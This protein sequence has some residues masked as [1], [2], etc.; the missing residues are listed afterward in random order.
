M[1]TTTEATRNDA[2][3]ADSRRV[4]LV[5]SDSHIGPTL[6]QLRSYCT[7]NLRDDLDAEVR[8]RDALRAAHESAFAIISNEVLDAQEWNC[9]TDGHHDMDARIRDMDVAGIAAQVIF[10]G[11]QNGEPIPFQGAP[12]SGVKA[13]THDLGRAAEG[14]KMYNRWLADAVSLQPERHVGAAQIPFWDVDATVAELRR[15]H[16]A[17][18]RA[19]NFPAMRAWLPAYDDAVWE[20]LWS[21]CEELDLSLACH[22]GGAVPAN[23]TGPASLALFAL[24]DGGTFGRRAVNWMTLGGVFERHPDLRIILTELSWLAVWFGPMMTEMDSVYYSSPQLG[25]REFLPKPPSEYLKKNVFIGASF[26]SR[27]EALAA[28]EGGYED[29]VIW[30]SDYPHCEG[31]WRYAD[32]PAEQRSFQLASMRMTFAGLDAEAVAKMCGANGVEAYGLD[33]VKLQAVADRI[34]FTPEEVTEP[35]GEAEMPEEIGMSFGFRSGPWN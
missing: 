16:A 8:A 25:I 24:E 21:L 4:V 13:P 10:H 30:G 2:P 35:L 29:R 15:A 23:F 12:L 11:S 17:G 9:Q 28:T 5:S 27:Q 1:S 6:E 19:V 22:G 33:P 32:D 14:L 20:P 18:L 3:R 31:A 7:K 26:L 34:G